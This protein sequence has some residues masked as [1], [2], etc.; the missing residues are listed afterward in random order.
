[1]K[2]VVIKENLHE[3]DKNAAKTPAVIHYAKQNNRI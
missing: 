1:M 3:N 2:K